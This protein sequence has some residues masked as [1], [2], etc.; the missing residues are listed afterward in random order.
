L[1]D[2]GVRGIHLYT[3]NKSDATRAIFQNLGVKTAADLR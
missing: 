3:L 1:L 2:K